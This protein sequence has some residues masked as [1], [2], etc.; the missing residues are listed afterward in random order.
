MNKL[1]QLKTAGVPVADFLADEEGVGTIEI[2]LI[3]V[4]LI[5][6]VL[7]FRT[8]LTALIKKVFDA[9]DQSAAELYENKT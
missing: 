4:V 2:V 6:L 3:L 9:M 5:A 8:R 1:A 7:I